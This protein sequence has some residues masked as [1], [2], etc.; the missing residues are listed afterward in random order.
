MPRGINLEL[1][2][3]EH[4]PL[5]AQPTALPGACAILLLL[6][7]LLLLVVVLPP[8]CSTLSMATKP[9]SSSRAAAK[10]DRTARRAAAGSPAPSELLT[11]TEQATDRPKTSMKLWGGEAVAV[12]GELLGTTVGTM[13]AGPCS[14]GKVVG[15]L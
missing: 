9:A 13:I 11:R 8:T 4:L 14:Y 1:C 3:Q 15:C 5:R 6:L 12:R 10:E 7:L 2:R